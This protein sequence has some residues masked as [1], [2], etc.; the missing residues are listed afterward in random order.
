MH[1]PTRVAPRPERRNIRTRT[2]LSS[3]HDAESEQRKYLVVAVNMSRRANAGCK[4][5]TIVAE[6]EAA[7]RV[8]PQRIE[9][10]TN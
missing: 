5:T 2:K 7:V 8:I 9:R 1:H 6:K 4:A 10:K 3:Q